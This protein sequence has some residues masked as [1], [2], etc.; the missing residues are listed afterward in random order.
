MCVIYTFLYLEYI[1]LRKVLAHNK[2]PKIVL[3]TIDNPQT[4][5]DE[6]SLNFRFDKLYPLSIY[7]EVND[8]LIA[9]NDRSILSQFF[10]MGRLS[11]AHINYSNEKPS[12]DNP[13][14]EDGSMP[15]IRVN[16]KSKR[17]FITQKTT[18]TKHKEQKDKLGALKSIQDLCR[19]NLLY[20]DRNLWWT[21][22]LHFLDA[23]WV[24]H[25]NAIP[26]NPLNRYAK[27][28]MERTYKELYGELS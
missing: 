23:G 3:L 11:K 9:Q 1:V 28:W 18:Y 21:D 6:K 8:E 26:R 16:P 12:K 27:Y 13:L 24:Y 10:L 17:E 25:Y 4:L 20:V 22:E 2:P 19:K 5:L 14:L 7:N 15:F